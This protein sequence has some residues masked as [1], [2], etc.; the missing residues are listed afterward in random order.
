MRG[1]IKVAYTASCMSL[2]LFVCLSS[3]D[4]SQ[5]EDSRVSPPF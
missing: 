5:K 4:L 2:Y 1:K 3:L